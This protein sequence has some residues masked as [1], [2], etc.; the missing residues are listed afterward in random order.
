MDEEDDGS[1]TD[2]LIAVPENATKRTRNT[3]KKHDFLMDTGGDDDV[4]Q[5][6]Q[7]QF[8]EAMEKLEEMKG[9]VAS[10]E[11]R[12]LTLL[13][14]ENALLDEASRGPDFMEAW[15]KLE[16][17]DF[18]L[19][20]LKVRCRG[21]KGKTIEE[22]G[23]RVKRGTR[24]GE[25]RD[26][27]VDNETGLNSFEI[28]WN[29]V[30]QMEWVGTLDVL[31][32]AADH[33]DNE[34]VVSPSEDARHV[35]LFLRGVLSMVNVQVH[36]YLIEDYL[37]AK[38]RCDAADLPP[39]KKEQTMKLRK[40]AL[41]DIKDTRASDTM[42]QYELELL[43]ESDKNL[44]ADLKKD[45]S[46]VELLE[47]RPYCDTETLGFVD[48]ECE[49]QTRHMVFVNHFVRGAQASWKLG[50]PTSLVSCMAPISAGE[51]RNGELP[52][53][54]R[55]DSWEAKHTRCTI[56][57]GDAVKCGLGTRAMLA[58][59]R[60]G[61]GETGCYKWLS[62]CPLYR[63][64]DFT[65]PEHWGEPVATSENSSKVSPTR[66]HKHFYKSALELSDTSTQDW[67]VFRV[68]VNG[69]EPV[70]T[71]KRN[72][73]NAHENS[74]SRL[75]NGSKKDKGR[76]FDVQEW[77]DKVDWLRDLVEKNGIK[78]IMDK[79]GDADRQKE[80]IDMCM[81]VLHDKGGSSL[82][83]RQNE[84]HLYPEGY[85]LRID[86]VVEVLSGAGVSAKDLEM[87]SCALHILDSFTAAC[88]RPQ[89]S[90]GFLACQAHRKRG[91]LVFVLPPIGKNSNTLVKSVL[92]MVVN[93]TKADRTAG[94]FYY[95]V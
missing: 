28:K 19:Y 88:L 57:L 5:R 6:L 60:V 47:L 36:K 94:E 43:G 77:E 55:L 78:P 62:H 95:H 66:R 31:R 53:G 41:E 85:K 15:Q 2:G 61:D 45:K 54:I 72:E 7:K 80:V 12:S 67:G 22:K 68:L 75:G 52:E 91:R 81:E 42:T 90:L 17:N 23:T 39:G 87:F 21:R 37:K 79:L 9:M 30:G 93:H 58:R 11:M 82:G 27:E 26:F 71:D 69:Y 18:R 70:A 49:F 40:Q 73:A 46:F 83:K 84:D 44:V 63:L 24:T 33:G 8:Q 51:G 32:M 13:G 50:R 20:G 74:L 10:P 16:K 64:L 29:G 89:D 35:G 34:D 48:Q 86:E 1:D 14:V 92:G 4:E 65:R 38:R 3:A 76:L 25:V 59:A 56:K